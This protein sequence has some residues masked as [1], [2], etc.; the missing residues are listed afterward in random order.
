M[1]CKYKL[2][3]KEATCKESP[4]MFKENA[5]LRFSFT[6]SMEQAN[7]I[8]VAIEQALKGGA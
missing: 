7:K 6:G 3:I 5:K 4:G 2:S 1:K 8:K